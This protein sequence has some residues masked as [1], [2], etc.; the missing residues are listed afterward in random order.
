MNHE[1]SAPPAVFVSAMVV[2]CTNPT[3]VA[4]PGRSRRR[5]IVTA[6]QFLEHSDGGVDCFTIGIIDAV[7]PVGEQPARPVSRAQDSPERVHSSG[8]A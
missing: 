5:G 2:A 7:D 3:L 1:R 8:A 6:S 4:T